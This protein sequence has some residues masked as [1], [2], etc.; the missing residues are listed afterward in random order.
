M[1][2]PVLHNISIR[3]HHESALMGGRF[4]TK[5]TRSFVSRR[6]RSLLMLGSILQAA[7]AAPLSY[8]VDLTP[9]QDRELQT[10]LEASS[11]LL[12]LAQAP[13][14]PSA[15]GLV[16][17]AKQDR[18]RM[19]TALRSRGYYAG[20]VRVTI[21]GN[22][23]HLDDLIEQTEAI[24]GDEPIAVVVQVEP[25][26]LF[27][28]G[29]FEVLDAATGRPDPRVRVDRSRLQIG[30]GDPARA[31]D[32]LRAEAAVIEQVSQRGYPFARV[33][34]RHVVVDHATRE[35]EV[36]LVAEPGPFARFGAMRIQGLEH[37][38][39]DFIRDLGGIAPGDPYSPESIDRMSDKL[40]ELEVFSRLRVE[41]ADAL[42]ERGRL[43]VTL[44]VKE[45]PR[46][47]IGIGADFNTSEGF[48]ARF[49]WRHRNLFGRAESL[50]VQTEVARLGENPPEDVD[51]DFNLRYTKPGFL[52]RDQTLS[53]E[54][55]GGRETPDAYRRE[56]LE[57]FVGLERRLTKTLKGSA[58]IQAERS[59]VDDPNASEPLYFL[60]VPISLR[61]D[62]S[63]DL[64]DPS[65]G[66]RLAL[67]LRPY[68][69]D[70][71]FLRTEL[72]TVAYFA[73]DQE[74]DRVL[75]ARV[76]L[77]SILG[78]ELSSVPSDKR[79]FAGGGGSVR[80]FASQAIGPRTPDGRPRGGRSLLEIGFEARLGISDK[81]GLVPFVEG[82]QVFENAL[83]DLSERLQFGVGLGLRYLTPIGPLR[84][85][86]A[87]PLDKAEDDDY[88]F[89]ISIGQAF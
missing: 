69:V 71:T 76:R 74:S 55:S 8:E 46:R 80:G 31:A 16:R 38:D 45:R 70:R 51:Y 37:M 64:L 68:F 39:G 61:L 77:G 53:A 72:A 84:F 36:T 88:Q 35:M 43:P 29:R 2:A 27:L 86:L 18:Q 56:A 12:A 78:E 67:D 30:L 63:D 66:H 22:P 23:L 24:V 54:F 1:L 82:G 58:G 25:G 60:S 79:F 9:L 19:L 44:I 10:A 75:A 20:D 49:R 50:Q 40:A 13:E 52:A 26:P 33:P 83:P 62:T 14:Q 32:V 4:P 42:D 11:N 3:Q 48:G 17:R 47:M 73:V 85:D 81:I 59:R 5:V 87:F 6:L 7:A 15:A 21:A 65:R 28:I 41:T 57:S 89:Y 34:A